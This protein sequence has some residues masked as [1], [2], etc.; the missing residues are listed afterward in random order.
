[1]FSAYSL[2]Y[3]RLMNRKQTKQLKGL[4]SLF[5]ILFLI[6]PIVWAETPHYS[7][8]LRIKLSQDELN[9]SQAPPPQNGTIKP[10]ATKKVTY[11]VCAG[12]YSVKSDAEKHL[13]TLRQFGFSPKLNV[14]NQNNYRVVLGKSDK[15]SKAEEVKSDFGKKGVAC[16]IEKE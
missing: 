10:D 2:P 9:R 15:R 7:S 4:V 12:R 13:Q 1:M 8:T 3:S 5:A 14:N 11:L 6:E 16:F